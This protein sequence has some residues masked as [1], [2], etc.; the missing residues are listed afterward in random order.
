LSSKIVASVTQHYDVK[1]VTDKNLYKE[2]IDSKC[3]VPI[4]KH[5]ANKPLKDFLCQPELT[6]LFS[7]TFSDTAVLEF[8]PKELITFVV[9]RIQS[10]KNVF[11]I[12]D[13]FNWIIYRAI[14]KLLTRSTNKLEMDWRVFALRLYILIETCKL[15]KEDAQS[16]L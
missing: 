1:L 11:S 5:S 4:A 2:I 12:H 16:N 7:E 6:N 14:P 3:S 8:V 13:S 10:N 15:M 9:E